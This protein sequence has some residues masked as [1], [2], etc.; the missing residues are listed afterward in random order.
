[1]TEVVTRQI[2]DMIRKGDFPPDTKLPSQR[3]LAEQLG[4]SR[5][6]LR[7]A[8]MTLETLGLLRT[9]PARGTFVVDAAKTDSKQ[10]VAW[11]FGGSF[12]LQDVFETRI[13]VE[14]ELCRMAAPVMTDA[15]LSVLDA[16]CQTFETTWHRGDLVAHVEADLA[17]HAQ[18]ADA[19]PNRMLHG[20]YQSINEILT[21]SQRAPIPRTH[22]SRMQASM[23]EHRAILSAL[24][25]RD[26]A[27]AAQAMRAH[28]KNTARIAGVETKR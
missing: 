27:A 17:F 22:V 3:I 15:D 18:I 6:S 4:V 23:E 25:R 24:R 8:L 10:P 11:R 7:E 26:G 9:L 16:A 14:A 20:F 12:S 19:C 5:A 1:M 2:Q 28:I 21:E 13:L